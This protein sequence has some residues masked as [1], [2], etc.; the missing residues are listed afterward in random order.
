MALRR[1]FC[2]FVE[3]EHGR[4]VHQHETLT[5]QIEENL[6]RFLQFF[7]SWEAYLSDLP[8]PVAEQ[9]SPAVHCHIKPLASGSAVRRD[10][11]F[12]DIQVPVRGAI[13]ID[14]E[15]AAF[16]RVMSSHPPIPWL[17]VKGVSDYADAEKDA[18][19][20]D[21]AMRTSALYALSVLQAYV[22]S[23]RL[24]RQQQ[25][26]TAQTAASPAG[27]GAPYG[28]GTTTVAQTIA[29]CEQGT[30]AQSGRPSPPQQP[31]TF[32]RRYDAHASRV[33][34]VV[35]E[36][37]GTRIAS[38]GADGTVRIWKA[39]SGEALL[40]YRGHTHLLN[41]INIHASISTVAWSPDGERIASAGSGT[42]V[43]I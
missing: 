13:V 37:V 31:G 16:G 40:T 4:Q 30:G 28:A 14:L 23:E 1:W 33:L 27:N 38:A 12:Q 8:H 17:I 3:D 10:N 21:Y 32:V 9:P 19:Y 29:S 36:P 22:T 18:S 35:W 34:A 7:S 20:H 25:P 43:H 39:E 5:Y 6:L 42:K 15:G 2:T 24:P 26:A 41:S 11:P